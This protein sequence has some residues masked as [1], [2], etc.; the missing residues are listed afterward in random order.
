MAYEADTRQAEKFVNELKLEGCRAVNTPGPK[1]TPKHVAED[2]P[3]PPS[4]AIAFRT[5]GPRELHG[6]RPT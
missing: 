3:L 6:G 5:E 2:K 1:H 4:Q